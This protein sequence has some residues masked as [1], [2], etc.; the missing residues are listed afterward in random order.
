MSTLSGAEKP[1]VFIARGALKHGFWTR[2]PDSFQDSMWGRS[3]QGPLM[4]LPPSHG[5]A[6][7]LLPLSVSL[8]RDQDISGL[9]VPILV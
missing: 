5:N 7:R 6:L 1:P 2:G 9:E 8:F 3:Y 4:S